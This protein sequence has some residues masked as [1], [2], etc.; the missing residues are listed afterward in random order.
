MLLEY[1]EE[2]L[3]CRHV[4]VCFKK[5]RDDRA[6]LIRTFMFLSFALVAP[7]SHRL[8][9]SSD[10]VYLAYAIQSDSDSEDDEFN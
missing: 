8:A 9:V 10:M 1:A 3:R 6:F 7:G 2:V 5:N 4:I